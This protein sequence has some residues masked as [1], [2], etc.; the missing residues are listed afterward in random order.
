MVHTGAVVAGSFAAILAALVASPALQ[1]EVVFLHRFN[2]PPVDF[3][4]PSRDQ[5]YAGLG[6]EFLSPLLGLYRGLNATSERIDDGRLGAWLAHRDRSG[7]AG[8]PKRVALYLH[9]NGENRAWAPAVR[10]VRALASTRYC[11]DVVAFDYAGFGDSAGEPT[12]EG[13]YGDAMAAYEWARGRFP[14]REVLLYGHSLGSVI[15][16]RLASRLCAARDRGGPKPPRALVIEGA[17]SGGLDVVLSFLPFLS[18]LR[19]LLEA[20]LAFEF[21]ALG[22]AQKIPTT[23]VPR[24]FQFHG[25]RDMT[26]GVALGRKVAEALAWGRVIRTG[27]ANTVFV[28]VPGAGHESA[29]DD[30]ALQA[31]LEAFLRPGG[32]S[33]KHRGDLLEDAP[34]GTAGTTIG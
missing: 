24:V 30:P 33:W 6:G 21:D 32:D 13:A 7:C 18:P 23:C 5:G 27:A 26:I 25:A 29:F 15:A 28:E 8:R 11:Y 4:A 34:L 17:L 12:E 9:G 1:R 22:P 20:Q 3:S 19:G 31:A 14:D 10:K 2:W 16:L